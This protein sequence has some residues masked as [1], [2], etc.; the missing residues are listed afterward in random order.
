MLAVIERPLFAVGLAMKKAYDGLSNARRLA[1][2]CVGALSL[3]TGACAGVTDA[4][5][6]VEAP[7]L[8][9]EL[10]D[11]ITLLDTATEKSAALMTR[12]GRVHLIAVTTGGDA[13]H[14]VV[15]ERGIE[16]KHKVGVD[17]HRYREN[18]AITDDADGRI[19]LAIHDKYWIWEKG[20]WRL[21]GRNRC[22]LLTHAG[23]FVACV[24]EA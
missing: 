11:E 15:S 9:I 21:V 5:N 13:L 24:T 16:E 6:V 18:L 8:G 2:F 22:A 10:G 4:A 19:H 3:L 17:R 12:D 20:A 23:D 1:R 14:V 7:P